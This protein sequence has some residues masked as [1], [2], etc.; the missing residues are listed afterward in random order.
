MV[1][2]RVSG[3]FVHV[4]RACNGRSTSLRPDTKTMASQIPQDLEKGRSVQ[5]VRFTTVNRYEESVEIELKEE[6][7]SGNDTEGNIPSADLN[8]HAVGGDDVPGSTTQKP[9]QPG[10]H[11][12]LESQGWGHIDGGWGWVVVMAAVAMQIMQNIIVILQG[13]M[14]PYAAEKFQSEPTELVYGTFSMFNGCRYMTGKS[15]I[16]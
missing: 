5:L 1:S 3:H 15:M 12:L 11:G 7:K 9:H 13:Y 16:S 8:H 4:H 14:L 2:T 6:G 10:Q